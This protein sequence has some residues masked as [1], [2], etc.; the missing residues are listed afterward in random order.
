MVLM[1]PHPHPHQLISCATRRAYNPVCV[2]THTRLVPCM[3][4]CWG[5]AMSQTSTLGFLHGCDAGLHSVVLRAL[6]C[7]ERLCWTLPPHYPLQSNASPTSSD[8][9]P[10][11]LPPPSSVPLPPPSVPLPPSSSS[12]L[13]PSSSHALLTSHRPGIQRLVPPGRL[14]GPHQRRQVSAGV[15]T[16]TLGLGRMRFVRRP[17]TDKHR[18]PVHTTTPP[19]PHLGPAPTLMM[20]LSH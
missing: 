9:Y 3:A 7:P 15:W 16:I 5:C 10:A 4:C 6:C 11:P 12:L 1:P 2:P 13:L 18:C 8:W 14:R 20:H 17:Y 19:T